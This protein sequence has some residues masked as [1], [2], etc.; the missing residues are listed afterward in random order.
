MSWIAALAMTLI[1]VMI[2]RLATIL[3]MFG[4]YQTEEGKDLRG[5]IGNGI[6]LTIVTVV[7][8][9]AMTLILPFRFLVKPQRISLLWTSEEGI[10]A[11]LRKRMAEIAAEKDGE[12]AQ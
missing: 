8:S 7:T 10:I 12:V 6:L 5:L 3:S 1:T 2:I 9:I 4:L 11:H